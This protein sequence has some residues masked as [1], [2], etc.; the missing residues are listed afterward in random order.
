M[1]HQALGSWFR[2]TRHALIRGWP[3]AALLSQTAYCLSPSVGTG[4][5][6]EDIYY[7]AMIPSGPILHGTTWLAETIE[8]VKYSIIVGRFYPI[9]PVITA[10]AF[11]L[12]QNVAF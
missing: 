9:T 6:A 10:L 1:F 8:A 7:S 4:Y 5:W 12:F 11:V 3:P 2:Q